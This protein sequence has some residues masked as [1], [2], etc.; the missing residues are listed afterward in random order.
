[1]D[2]TNRVK[3]WANPSP[4]ALVA[5]ALACFCFFALLTGR[6]TPAA[7]PL[8]AIWLACC[9]IIQIVAAILD[10]KAGNLSGG[11][12]FLFF[13]CFFMLASGIEMYLKFK[14]GLAGTVL[15]S[16]LDGWAWLTMA[17]VLWLWTPAYFKNPL[18]MTFLV[19]GVDIV[20]PI[21]AFRDLGIIP[22][23]SGAI[24]GWI[25]LITGSIAIYYCSTMI[26]NGVYGRKVY[27]LPGPIVKERKESTNSVPGNVKNNAS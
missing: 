5:L 6:V 13:S 4:A 27:P 19:L 18:L 23:S 12:L 15:D 16:R 9:F 8:L 2:Q 20:V 21:I 10:L 24:A 14:M 26:V 11:N 25:L 17:F 22:E 7:T 1:M 3:E